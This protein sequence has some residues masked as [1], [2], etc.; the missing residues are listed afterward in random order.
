MNILEQS[1]SRHY[2]GRAFF[3]AG[4][5]E[6]LNAPREAGQPTLISELSLAVKETPVAARLRRLRRA[7]LYEDTNVGIDALATRT[8]SKAVTP[9]NGFTPSGL[10]IPRT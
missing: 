10:K 6:T 5:A 1:E 3:T 9:G 4:G 2:E 7:T 8:L